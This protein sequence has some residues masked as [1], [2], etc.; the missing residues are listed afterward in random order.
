MSR[1]KMKADDLNPFENLAN[2]IILQAVKD[3]KESLKDI[4]KIVKEQEETLKRKPTQAELNIIYKD[5]KDDLNRKIR[6]KE[7]VERFFDSE[8]YKQLTSVDS[9]YLISKL[10]EEVEY[11]DTILRR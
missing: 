11:D 10:K 5:F 4:K 1:Y 9:E 8:W 3:Y 2:G 7:E 6:I